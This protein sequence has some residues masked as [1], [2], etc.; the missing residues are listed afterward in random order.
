MGGSRFFVYEPF[1]EPFA[2]K[3]KLHLIDSLFVGGG[4]V[5]RGWNVQL[6]VSMI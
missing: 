4:G 5:R 1:L 3:K 2:W 6:K